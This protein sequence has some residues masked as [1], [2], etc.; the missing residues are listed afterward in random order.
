MAKKS[1]KKS[2][3]VPSAEKTLADYV[4][5]IKGHIENKG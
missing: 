5:Y 2:P 3:I 1:N 4:T